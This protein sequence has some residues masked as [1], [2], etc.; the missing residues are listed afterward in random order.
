MQPATVYHKTAH[1]AHDCLLADGLPL[2]PVLACHWAMPAF[3]LL[4]LRP[5]G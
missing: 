4:P 2:T 3:T 1:F 5:V